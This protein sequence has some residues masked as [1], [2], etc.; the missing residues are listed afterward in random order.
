MTRIDR[1]AFR[2]DRAMRRRPLRWGM[3]G[4]AWLLYWS[5]KTV[6]IFPPAWYVVGVVIACMPAALVA[7]AMARADR[8]R[9]KYRLDQEGQVVAP[10]RGYR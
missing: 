8:L 7:L 9:R 1:A 10:K 3:R 6:R 2:I 4:A 5:L